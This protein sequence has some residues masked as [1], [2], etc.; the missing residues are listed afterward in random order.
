VSD[1][2]R[3]PAGGAAPPDTIARRV[4]FPLVVAA[5]VFA[6]AAVS[7]TALIWRMEL[8]RLQVERARVA[9]L[10]GNHARALQISIERALTAAYSLAAL[11]RLG[12]GTVANFDAIVGEM[13]PYYPGAS[14]LELAP[15]GVISQVMPRAGNEKAVG[16]DL[17]RDPAQRKEAAIARDTGKLTLAGPINLVQGGLGIAGRLP[18]FLDDGRGNPSFWGFTLVVIRF[19]GALV[20]ARFT[21]MVE[22]GFHYELWRMHPGSGQRQ[23]IDASSPAPLVEP[24]EYSLALP[25]GAWMLSV[26]P[27]RGWGDPSGLLLKAALGLAFSLILA[28][29]AKLMVELKVH[30]QGLQ[31]LVARRTAE[32]RT[33]EQKF[34]ELLENMHLLAVILDREGAITFCNRYLLAQTGWSAGEVRGA[35]WFDRF[36]PPADGAAAK[37]LFAEA[38]AGAPLP[39]H[40]EGTIKTRGGGQRI[41]VWDTTLL[42]GAGDEFVGAANIGLDVTDHRNVEARLLQSQKMEAVG[43]LAGGIAHDFNNLLTP[44]LGYSEMLKSDVLA[45]GGDVGQVELITAAAL[46][47]RDLTRQLLSFGRKQT[48]DIQIV[49]VNEVVASFA[50]ILRRTIRESIEIKLETSTAPACIR[51]DRTQI[52]QLVM[53]LVVNAQ[54]A[55]ANKGVITIETGPVD[56]DAEFVRSH[57]EARQG[58]CV[59]LTVRDT[60]SGIDEAVLPRIFEPFFSTKDVGSGAGLG[61]A[62]VYGIVQQHE[63]NVWVSSGPERGTVFKIA[64]PRVDGIPGASVKPP[65]PAPRPEKA[66]GTIL[67]VEDNEAVLTMVRSLL[68]GCGYTVIGTQDPLLALQLAADAR[69]DLLVTDVVMPGMN[70]PELHRRLL[71]AHPG[72]NVLF[73]S[74]YTNHVVA[75][76]VELKEGVNFIRK[77]FPVDDMARKVAAII[78]A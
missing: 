54:D 63:G 8:Q 11:V 78:G 14:A 17:L 39:A 9:D 59:M 26:S 30:Q 46:K 7:A 70:G 68:S 16:F 20:P 62:T 57:P 52:E 12:N 67:L 42:K 55:I 73:M 43:K 1:N 19:P 56:L 69:I 10:A 38:M 27:A 18:V 72:L 64:F 40:H 53:N 76:H 74:G 6:L 71:A 51:A 21:Q 45:A 29:M 2:E 33:S 25:N 35:N 44:I 24:V 31:S 37:A 36:I 34:S 77:P 4:P 66:S 50:G 65:E 75:Q 48:L 32:I 28:Y 15:A 5:L 47:A 23:V 61:L 49:D 22:R 3:N 41:I 13:L 58:R 60:G